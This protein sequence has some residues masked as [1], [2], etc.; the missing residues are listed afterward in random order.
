MHTVSTSFTIAQYCQEL[1]DKTIMVNREYQRSDKVWP[2]EAQS[3]LIDTIV[4]G[5]PVP[6]LSLYQVTDPLSYKTV[7]EIVD[8]QQRSKAILAFR[9]N[10]LPLPRRTRVEGG[11]GKL[12]REL[13]REHQMAFLEYGLT[14]DLFVS[15]TRD[16]IREVFRRINSYMVPLNP[17]ENRHAT[18]QGPFKWFMYEMSERYSQVMVDIGAFGDRQ[19]IR[20][21]DVKLYCE[22]VHALCN[23]ITTTSKRSIDRL[24]E[25]LDANF[26]A[27]DEL[28]RRFEHA[29]TCVAS[30]SELHGGPLVRPH[31][32]YSLLLAIMHLE[33]PAQSLSSAYSVPQRL[34]IVRARA[35]EQLSTLAEALEMGAPKHDLIPF[36]LA[37]SSKTNVKAN[38][39]KRFQ[40]MC[41]ALTS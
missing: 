34:T 2:A 11:A 3:F 41:K 39:I 1:Q 31:N 6:K 19:L 23:G 10:E 20:M 25:N 18:Y 15:A 24:Y 35:I 30:F 16:E 36:V 12:F 40:Y 38:R 29:M 37:A 9:N 21:G 7:K 8:G 13:P 33:E 5:F 4:Q 28:R 32:L 26:D 27:E 17:E 22:V 14:A